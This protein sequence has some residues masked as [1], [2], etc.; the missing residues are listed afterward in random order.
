MATTMNAG[1]LTSQIRYLPALVPD[2][3]T[4]ATLATAGAATPAFSYT[5][6]GQKRLVT[7]RGLQHANT[8]GVNLVVS[9]DTRNSKT[10]GS[11]ADALWTP[12]DPVAEQQWNA[13]AW[14]SLVVTAQNTTAANIDTYWLAANL[15]VQ[16]PDVAQK[17]KWTQPLTAAD[18]AL[19]EKAGLIGTNPRGVLPRTFEWIRQNEY[20]NQIVNAVPSAK[21]VNLAANVAQTIADA[22]AGANEMLVL[23]GLAVSPGAG[24]ST[25]GLKVIVSVDNGDLDLQWDAY[26]LGSGKPAP[27]F[28]QAQKNIVVQVIASEAVNTVH[29]AALIWHVRLTDEI[30]VRLLELTSGPVYDKIQSGVL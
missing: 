16:N 10:I 17:I 28:L 15:L 26:P 6:L 14:N 27:W 20:Q 9:A 22:S 24:T 23:A 5:G 7:L 11:A 2:A 1:V 13:G 4:I 25:D 8:S 18:Q 12:F 21:T 29:C 19:A 30:R 3:T